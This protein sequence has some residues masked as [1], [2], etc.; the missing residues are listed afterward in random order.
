MFQV[1]SRKHNV[2]ISVL[3]Q[4]N[5]TFNGKIGKSFEDLQTQG[6]IGV[7][8]LGTLLYDNL[9]FILKEENE[10]DLVFAID[11]VNFDVTMSKNIVKT[12]IS[13]RDGT[14]KEYNN[15]G[16]FIITGAGV[17]TNPDGKLFPEDALNSF[18]RVVRA[19]SEVDII[20]RILNDHFG[21]NSVVI[22]DYKVKPNTGASGVN[23]AFRMISETPFDIRE[24]IIT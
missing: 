16:D 2:I 11:A 14:V 19:K 9:K 24:F 20:S 18:M 21:I 22:E 23:I 1:N 6:T 8:D 5:L 10:S 13:G 4:A 3:A 17:L 15:D 7:S 12:A